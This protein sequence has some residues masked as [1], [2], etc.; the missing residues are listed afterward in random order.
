MSE[1]TPTTEQVR[2][3]WA[4]DGTHQPAAKSYDYGESRNEFDRWLARHDAEVKAEALRE[5]AATLEAVPDYT[6]TEYDKGRVDQ[7]HATVEELRVRA[8]RQE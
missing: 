1:Y 3:F 5:Y 4:S 2:N 6:P 8:D 7:R